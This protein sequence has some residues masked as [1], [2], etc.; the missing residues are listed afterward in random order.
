MNS[1]SSNTVQ[2]GNPSTGKS[3]HEILAD[4]LLAANEAASLLLTVNN[5]ASVDEVL[6]CALEIIGRAVDADRVF[7]W[8]DKEPLEDMVL[9]NLFV[10]TGKRASDAPEV[11]IEVS[12]PFD[13]YTVWMEKFRS[14]ECVYKTFSDM[15]ADE[16]AFFNT[17]N[18]KTVFFIPLFC[19]NALWGV[20]SIDD[21]MQERSFSEDE[22]ITLKSIAL[23]VASVI[24]Y[25]KTT[26]DLIAINE[27]G[28]AARKVKNAFLSNMSHEVRTPLN[29]IVGMANVGERADDIDEKDYALA[30]I[31][32]ASTHLLEII[33]N[34][35]D[36][37]RIEEG[38]LELVPEEFAFR[39]TVD[40]VLTVI[41]PVATEKNQIIDVFIDDAIPNNVVGDDLRFR[42]LIS[43]L[44]SNSVKFTPIYGK[45][46]LDIS[47]TGETDKH[48]ELQ[49]V[50]KDNGIGISEEQRERIFLAFE[51]GNGALN[52]DYGG[53]GLGLPISKRIV[54]L[55]D[56]K[57][58]IESEQ[59]KGTAIY[60]TVQLVK[61]RIADTLHG[62]ADVSDDAHDV[63]VG[64][65]VPGE[66][67]G[68][69]LLIAEDIEINREILIALLKDSGLIIEC[70]EDGQ[71]AVNMV[72]F[73]VEKY[74]IVFMDLQMPNLGGLDAARQIRELPER[75]RGRLPIIAMTAN[76]LKED[77][78]ACMEAGMDDHLSKP[79]DIEKVLEKLRKYL[80]Q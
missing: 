63:N 17:F 26:L 61:S 52:R 12:A 33:S 42:Q 74:D 58:W 70:A 80:A 9:E 50:V 68:K 69:R 34:V 39:E 76:V 77:V 48:L 6:S 1:Q 28:N 4:L 3:D 53:T 62:N 10:W 45:I 38:R 67:A 22:I 46:S 31:K 71:I 18:T 27:E 72:M 40:K 41:K 59:N 15:T 24:N 36:M 79:L 51:Q 23:M 37:A 44:L 54:E 75:K 7:L 64:T 20:I 78:R 66:F 19:A 14:G 65:V 11:L 47:L 25:Q 21:C 29:A 8:R 55:M 32:D 56:G 43:N 35:L 73:N 16:R 57:I 30:K 60:L 49:L 13:S 5:L 2:S